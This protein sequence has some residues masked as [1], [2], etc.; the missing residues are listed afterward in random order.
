MCLKDNKT[1]M[2]EVV[3]HDGPGRIGKIDWA[4][5]KNLTPSLLHPRF[6][7][8]EPVSEKE[9]ITLNVLPDSFPKEQFYNVF[10]TNPANPYVYSDLTQSFDDQLKL[11]P[12]VLTVPCGIFIELDRKNTLRFLDNLLKN[13]TF[14]KEIAG[15]KHLAV[16]VF[17]SKF[18][19]LYEKQIDNLS[20]IGFDIYILKNLVDV[21]GSPRQLLEFI[22]SVREKIPPDS[23]LYFPGP[24][25]PSFYPHL[26]YSGVD[27]FDT[28]LM[29]REAR[30][31]R[32]LLEGSSKKIWDLTELPCNCQIC[33]SY[34]VFE[35]TKMP[36][37]ER[38]YKLLQ[39]NILF[40]VSVLKRIRLDIK[41]GFL[42]ERVELSSHYSPTLAACLRIFDRNHFT[43]LEEY[44]PIAKRGV[45]YC[46]GP[47][48][49]HRPEVERFRKRVSERY[50]PVKGIRTVIILPCS[51][52][53]PYSLSKSHEKFR[54]V[55][56]SVGEGLIQEAILSSPL[57]LVP[58]ELELVYPA[59][60]YDIPVTGDWDNE[61]IEIAS[62]S[63]LNYLEKLD[64]ETVVIA[65]LDG[66]YKEACLRASD[67]SG[68]EIIFTEIHGNVAGNESLSSLKKV[69]E[70]YADLSG[71]RQVRDTDLFKKIADY[72]FGIGAGEKL[73]PNYA[74]IK[75]DRK[76]NVKILLRREVVASFDRVYGLLTLTL[77]GAESLSTHGY[78]VEFDGD[79]L[80]G[81]NLLAP[82]VKDADS[83]IRPQDSVMIY[84]PSKEI[85]AVGISN[86]SGPEMKSS[87]RGVAVRLTEKKTD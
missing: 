77:R 8:I 55:I 17:Y 87:R 61:E 28:T 60:H 76:G 10:M 29:I 40:A 2:F 38:F 53:K 15:K 22:V 39:H 44:T 13:A 41:D 35:I 82:G 33:S 50:T 19:D 42:R 84:N 49:Y 36:P 68:R 47:E 62:A 24:V 14:F 64:K 6:P 86:M 20:Q 21:L 31:N 18:H 66:G 79:T 58:R 25:H 70:E 7:H 32:L 67:L 34:S 83:Q 73:I 65:H 46:I 5:E 74:D 72:Q 9:L 37:D 85:I 26:I 48:S 16:P 80:S 78:W 30:R 1:G 4:D 57:G 11:N 23:L 75:R 3:K 51:A 12:Q 63:L 54:K 71:S 52:K 59:A 81:S 43:F 56:K 69:L 27:L 45:M